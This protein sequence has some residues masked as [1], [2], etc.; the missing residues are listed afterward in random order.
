MLIPDE[1][2]ETNSAVP[3]AAIGVASHDNLQS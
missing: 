3:S 1:V 2:L